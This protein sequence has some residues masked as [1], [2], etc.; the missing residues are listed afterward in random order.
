M[1]KNFFKNFGEEHFILFGINKLNKIA[2][3]FYNSLIVVNNRLEILNEYK[4]QKLVPFGE[5]LPFEKIL[6]K[7]GIKKDHRRSRLIL[8]R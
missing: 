3:A 8:K 1:K 2:N 7:F 4:K 5:F 6:N